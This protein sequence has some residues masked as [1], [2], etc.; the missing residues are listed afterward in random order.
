MDKQ[1]LTPEELLRLNELNEK[2]IQ[3]TKNFGSLE[4]DLQAIIIEKN[5]VIAKLEEVT[6]ASENIALELQKKYGEGNVN[7][8][9][10][11]FIKR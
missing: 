1:F 6:E 9:T 5:K 3:L 8:D 2:R 10:G 4:F 11:E 7:I